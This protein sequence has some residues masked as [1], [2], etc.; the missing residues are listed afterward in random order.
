M[1]WL[2]EKPNETKFEKVI[3]DFITYFEPPYWLILLIGIMLGITLD[4]LIF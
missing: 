1:S 4:I 3:K 2:K